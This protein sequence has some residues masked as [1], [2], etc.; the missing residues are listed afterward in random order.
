MDYSGTFKEEG[1]FIP[2][3]Y[4]HIV[5][6]VWVAQEVSGHPPCHPGATPV[7]PPPAPPTLPTP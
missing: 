6:M 2:L 4:G 5:G 1:F 3:D 7:L